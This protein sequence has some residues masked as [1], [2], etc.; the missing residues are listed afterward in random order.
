MKTH[1]DLWQLGYIGLSIFQV[2]QGFKL[3]MSKK[4]TD[5]LTLNSLVY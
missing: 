2:A 3:D 4:V 5:C 1:N